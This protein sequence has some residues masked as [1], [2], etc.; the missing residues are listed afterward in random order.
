MDLDA[1]RDF[2]H[3]P[4][5]LKLALYCEGLRIDEDATAELHESRGILRTRA[6]LGSGLELVLPGNLWTNAPVAEDFCAQS[7]FLLTFR[8]GRFQVRHENGLAT[9]V[10]IAPRPTWYDLRCSTGKQM[11]RVGTLQGTYL[12][13]YA[14]NVCEFWTRK[15]REMCKFC[16]V[17]LNLGA[18]DASDKTQREVLEVVRMAKLQS[19]ITYV[20]FNTGHHEDEGYLDVLEPLVTAV[21]RETGLLVG[22][23]TPPHSDLERYR[24]LRELGV[25]RVSFCFELYDRERFDEICPGKSAT[26]GLD[27]YLE[28]MD[29]CAALGKKVNMHEPWVTN[30]EIIAGL[31]DPQTTIAAID[32]I[33]SVGAVPTVCV[34]RPLKGTA[35]AHLP[36]P[37]TEDMVPVFR[38][39]Y[40]ACMRHNLPIGLAPNVHVSLV[41]LPEECAWLSPR[42]SSWSFRTKQWRLEVKKRVFHHLFDRKVRGISQD[43]APVGSAVDGGEG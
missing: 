29:F 12:G 18:D 39:L 14:A 2:P 24:R 20:D 4:A 36:P 26:Y 31:E 9:D 17:G 11:S 41:M 8:K 25:N 22:V 28:T 37:K 3:N 38:H 5:L 23:Q 32:R 43:P 1:A 42:R 30:G 6:G 15:N 40:E 33:T 34:F 19:G 7:P 13:I 27:R 21:K 16:S 35:L 10:E